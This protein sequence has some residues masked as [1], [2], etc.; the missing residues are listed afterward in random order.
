MVRVRE[1]DDLKVR[2]PL[3]RLT[4]RRRRPVVLLAYQSERCTDGSTLS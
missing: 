1:N 2:L 4:K 3:D